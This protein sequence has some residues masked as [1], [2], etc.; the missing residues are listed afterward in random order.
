VKVIFGSN[1]QMMAGGQVTTKHNDRAFSTF[2]GISIDS[3]AKSEN[4]CNSIRYNCE[5]DSKAI[6]ARNSHTRQHNCPSL[7]MFRGISIKTSD[8]DE[9][10]MTPR[11]NKE[12]KQEVTITIVVI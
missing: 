4:H 7:S 11:P 5:S 6:D 10:T 1:R 9:K 8:E 2:R 12:I 3:S